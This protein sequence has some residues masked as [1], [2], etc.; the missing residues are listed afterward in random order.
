MARRMRSTFGCVQRVDRDR[1]RLR[2]WEEVG[3]EYRRRSETVRGT[4]RE[5]ERRLA[6]IRAGLDENARR[7]L[8]HVPTVREAYER[9]YL[10]DLELS[11]SEG[12]MARSTYKCRLSKWRVYV[13]PRWGESSVSEIDPLDLQSW[14][15]GMTRKPASDALAMLRKILDYCV[16]YGLVADNVA[17]RPYRMPTAQTDRAD[18]AYTLAEL[19]RIA[20]A[21]RGSY[22]EAPMLL[23]MFGGARTGESLGVRA[24]EVEAMGACGVALAVA[25]VRRQVLSDATVSERM[26]TATSA[27]ALVVPEPWGPRLLELAG[28]AR[29][30]GD[31]WLCGDN[32]GQP[33]SQNAYRAE[34]ARCCREAGVASRQP[35]AARRSWETYMRWDMRVDQWRVEQMMG[36]ALPGVT[37]VHYDK[38]TAPMFAE[39]VGEAFARRPFVRA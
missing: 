32:M 20:Q 22:A 7:R 25:H 10:P 18:G 27:R 34:W 6:E 2:W 3:G 16:L 15:L 5:A 36:H 13:G 12:R 8:R 35:R 14:L 24:D 23:C 38:P 17:R 19:D 29:D 31:A 30:R 39:V 37:G 9:W 21:A 28:A 4:R 11:V 33:L 26:K 1:Y